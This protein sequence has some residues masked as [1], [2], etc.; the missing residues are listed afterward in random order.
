MAFA[1]LVSGGLFDG[2]P[3][4]SQRGGPG[5]LTAKY[6]ESI[7]F[8][9]YYNQSCNDVAHLMHTYDHVSVGLNI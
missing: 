2:I 4:S 5:R 9:N 8:K 1:A 3:F 7:E 6:K